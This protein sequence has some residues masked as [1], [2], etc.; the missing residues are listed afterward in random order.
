[1]AKIWDVRQNATYLKL[2]S[3]FIIALTVFFIAIFSIREVN[4]LQGNYLLQVKFKYVEG[5]RPASP[6]RFCGVDVGE[7]KDVKVIEGAER[8]YVIVSAKVNKGVRIPKNAYFFINSLSLFGE[9]YL[10]VRPP[11][12]TE[13]YLRE[14]ELIEGISPVPLFNVFAT[15]Q[16]TMEEISA[17]LQEGEIK[18]SFENTLANL[19]Q[20]TYEV[21]G[22][23]IAAKDK[24]GTFGK[25]LYD[26]S[27]YNNINGLIENLNNKNGTIGRFLYDDSLYKTTEEFI[28]DLKAHPWKLLH[29]PKKEDYRSNDRDNADQKEK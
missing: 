2:G 11:E 15:F 5:L 10:E 14:G 26:D 13:E 27:L 22:L 23:I 12:K 19:E 3:F 18:T 16:K 28:A 8:P 29:K 9:K 4:F 6:V 25:L 1:M 24:K 21:K 20:A 7:V 17:F